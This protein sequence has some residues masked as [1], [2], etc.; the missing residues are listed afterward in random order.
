MNI[1]AA[2]GTGLVGSALTGYLTGLGH[3]VFILTRNASSKQNKD[4][5]TFVEWL[6]PGARPEDHLPDIDAVINLAGA[7]INS[8]WTEKQKQKIL[9]SRLD[10]AGE[11]N[12]LIG[13]LDRSPEVLINAS[14]VGW[15]GTSKTAEFTEKSSP[16][17]SNFLQH[18]CEQW[19]KEASR[20]ADA[21][22]RTVLARFGL[23]LDDSGGALPK[24]MF[25]YK[26]FAGGPI[27]SGDQWY[28]WVHLQDVIQ[29]ICFAIHH[30][31]MEG[32]LNVTA[33]NPERMRE[34]GRKLGSTLNRPHWAPVP[35]FVIRTALGDM[36]TLILEGQKVIPQK[37]LQHG[38]SFTYP[39]LE[40]ALQNIT[41]HSGR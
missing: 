7:S 21:G 30:K 31:N 13:A 16:A 23:I 39:N 34:F 28:S 1:L 38:F 35:A 9:Q 12:R 25:P 18:V 4:L 17:N 3:H 24:M 37:A 14:A 20:A 36:S 8:R 15:Y 26:L 2:G 27:G 40:K 19:E 5:V 10:A 6:Q 33:P 41:S 29:L 22:V 11:I 32:P